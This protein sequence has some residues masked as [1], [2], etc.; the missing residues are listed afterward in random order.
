M[1]EEI[2]IDELA[3]MSQKQFTE[4]QGELSSI[5]KDL[6]NLHHEIGVGF[7]A[8][9]ADFA[10][11]VA[12]IRDDVQKLNYAREIDELRTRVDRIEGNLEL[13]TQEG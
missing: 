2:T 1:P 4:I 10:A 8:A 11:G 7:Q 13:S 12:T 3:R 6:S 5:K 9:K